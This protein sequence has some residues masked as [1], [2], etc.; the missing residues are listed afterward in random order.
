M[1]GDREEECV[2]HLDEI[3]AGCCPH[4]AYALPYV[5]PLSGASAVWMASSKAVSLNGLARKATAP[6]CNAWARIASF[7]CA[8]IKIM[9][10]RAWL[11]RNCCC[12]SRPL[13]P[14]SRTSRSRHAVVC[15]C[16]DWQKAS[17][18]AKPPARHPTERRRLVRASRIASSSST[19]MISGD[20]AIGTFPGWC[21]CAQGTCLRQESVPRGAGRPLLY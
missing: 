17:A 3:D 2:G 16:P 11:E 19:I 1:L 6:A 8:V 21:V 9:G 7:P 14:G 20:A 13:L 4:R 18:E 12:S 10:I 15:T 5:P